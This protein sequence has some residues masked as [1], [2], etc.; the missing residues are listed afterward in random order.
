M[1]I[2]KFKKLIEDLENSTTQVLAAVA[3]STKATSAG[4][5]GTSYK[6]SSAANAGTSRVAHFASSGTGALA[7]T[8]LI[9]TSAII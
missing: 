6:A 5:S 1:A 7:G 3:L 4:N 8:N 9:Y 2:L